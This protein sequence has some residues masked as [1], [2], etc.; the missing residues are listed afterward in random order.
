MFVVTLRE[1]LESQRLEHT[2]HRAALISAMDNGDTGTMRQL[3]ADAPFT[4]E[5]KRYIDDL[6][7][8][9]GAAQPEGLVGNASFDGDAR[10]QG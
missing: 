6:L 3:L 5:Q 2:P 8:R 10:Q 7:D 9:W 4:T 1:W